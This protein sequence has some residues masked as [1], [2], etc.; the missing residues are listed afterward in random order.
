VKPSYK[1]F[2]LYV[3]QSLTGLGAVAGGIVASS[4]FAPI[5]SM[6]RLGPISPDLVL[7]LLSGIGIVSGVW[8]W[9]RC[10]VKASQ[11]LATRLSL[12][13][14]FAGAALWGFAGSWLISAIFITPTLK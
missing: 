4:S 3:V 8:L 10:S 12:V 14:A 7:V 9:R 13:L 6:I 11:R 1:L 2:P 5:W